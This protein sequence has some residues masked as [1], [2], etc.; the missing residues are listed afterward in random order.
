M[1][2]ML[3]ITVLLVVVMAA[4]GMRL[5][6]RPAKSTMFKQFRPADPVRDTMEFLGSSLASVFS[7]FQTQATGPV[8][9][10]TAWQPA[11]LNQ[12]RKYHKRSAWDNADLAEAFLNSHLYKPS[13]KVNYDDTIAKIYQNYDSDA[14]NYVASGL[15]QAFSP[16]KPFD[17]TKASKTLPKFKKQVTL[18]QL[19]HSPDYFAY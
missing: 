3:K 6:Q 1:M 8:V 4:M 12:L 13:A 10:L 19:K 15:K 11:R 17:K 2:N 16:L 14:A 7:P 9:E 18:S 5:T